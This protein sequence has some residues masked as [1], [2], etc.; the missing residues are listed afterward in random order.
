V[1]LVGF[2]I[3]VGACAS[4]PPIAR[5]PVVAPPPT[6]QSLEGFGAA[7]AGRVRTHALEFQLEFPLPDRPAWSTTDGPIW[8]VAEHPGTSSELAI[9]GW[10]ATRLV[11]RADCD[12]QARLSRS[13]IPKLS[14]D[15]IVEQRVVSLPSGFDS[16]L[17][18]GVVPDRGVVRG[19]AYLVGATVGRCF[20][21]VFTTQV[22][23]AAPEE[24][25]AR[26]LRVAV[27]EIFEQVRVRQIEDRGV[28]HRL[29]A[30]PR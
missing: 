9:R 26:R 16:E 14:D 12:Q 20:A 11:R 7:P 1:G 19:T 24:E 13:E 2:G 6:Q 17:I 29:V 4:A 21:A 8:F 23:G 22:H 27:S 28:R 30:T 5:S 18:V 10:R 25:V 3:A 15:S